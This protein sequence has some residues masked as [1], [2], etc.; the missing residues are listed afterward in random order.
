MVTVIRNGATCL[1]ESVV[2]DFCMSQLDL[3]LLLVL[4]I[5]FVFL[6]LPLVSLVA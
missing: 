4:V 2:F 1:W 5:L 3:A 6:L